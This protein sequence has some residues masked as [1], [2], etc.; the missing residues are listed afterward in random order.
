MPAAQ[1]AC[2]CSECRRAPRGF[3]IQDS[4][5]IKNHQEE[6]LHRLQTTL[7][8]QPVG[9]NR[10]DDV[11]GNQEQLDPMGP[12][13]PGM[14]I[15]GY[16]IDQDEDDPMFNWEDLGDEVNDDTSEGRSTSGNESEVT[17]TDMVSMT[18]SEGRH[19]S[20]AGAD[21]TGGEVNDLSDDPHY[22]ED[23][24]PSNHLFDTIPHHIR[25]SPRALAILPNLPP[26]VHRFVHHDHSTP[27]RIAW[28]Q[29]AVASVGG[30]TV[31]QVSIGL[32]SSNFMMASM[33]PA[34]ELAQPPTADPKEALSRIGV[35]PDS[36]LHRYAVCENEKCCVLFGNAEL[37][38]YD[39]DEG[40]AIDILRPDERCTS[41]IYFTKGRKRYPLKSMFF[42][43]PSAVLQTFF[44]DP[45]FVRDIQLW[46]MDNHEDDIGI[47]APIPTSVPVDRYRVL[48]NIM[49]GAAWRS[50]DCNVVREYFDTDNGP[51]MEDF[52]HGPPQRLVSMEFGLLA[53]INVDWFGVHD[54]KNCSI[55]AIYV[56][57]LNLPRH[58]FLRKR[59]TILAM[60]IPGPKIPTQTGFNNLIAPLIRDFKTLET[61]ILAFIAG[62]SHP[63]PVYLQVMFNVSDMPASRK[64]AGVKSHNSHWPCC[65]CRIRNRDLQDPLAYEWR[66]LPHMN[67]DTLVG[68]ASAH[69]TATVAQ[70]K[71]LEKD[72]G[73]KWSEAVKLSGFKHSDFSPPDTMHG[74]ALGMTHALVLWI[75][76]SGVLDEGDDGPD[77]YQLFEKALTGITWPSH[78]GRLVNGVVSMVTS[79]RDANNVKAD[80]WSRVRAAL[81]CALWLALRSDTNDQIAPSSTHNRLEIYRAVV[82]FSASL[83]VLLAKSITIDAAEEAQDLL[84]SV[85]KRFLLHGMNM[86]INW[87]IAMHYSQ[88]IRMYGPVG[89]Y[90]TW[91]YERNNGA[92]AKIHYFRG[93]HIQMVG[94]AARFWTKSQLLWGVLENPAPDISETE[95]SYIED[96]KCRLQRTRIQGTVLLNEMD[97]VG[98]GIE[99]PLGNRSTI[100]IRTHPLQLYPGILSYL[101]LALPGQRIRSYAAI[102]EEGSV[103]VQ[104]GHKEY[105]Y[106]RFNGFRFVSKSYTRSN[107]D[108]WALAVHPTDRALGMAACRVEM[109]LQ[110]CL[111]D[112]FGSLAD[113]VITVAAVRFL[114]PADEEILPWSFRSV[115]LAQ[116]LTHLPDEAIPPTVI[117]VSSLLAPVAV[118]EV[119]TIH[120]SRLVI[121]SYN[122]EHVED[123]MGLDQFDED[124]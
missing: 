76:R 101:R 87:H 84:S 116:Q 51:V 103:L 99:L 10:A 8:P 122:R 50:R 115:M 17:D 26:F 28:T 29:A 6:D 118:K 90:A 73:V 57:I 110:L 78:V 82:D 53:S 104:A 44:R 3:T 25:P 11:P 80:E 27:E 79:G 9:Y 124:E 21:I 96:L 22:L 16:D 48:T 12:E 83:R 31:D 72:H 43:P 20:D 69:R 30:A 33:A 105:P 13:E 102:Y 2:R 123:S 42:S 47:N 34:H 85:C 114:Q 94:T 45:N 77:R 67:A 86:T 117:S 108:R 18:E 112:T 49:D 61:G 121:M 93:D 41:R 35:S 71:V 120:G 60:V 65:H 23:I 52:R 100:N 39:H 63:A 1:R 91:S 19:P 113:T 38:T 15:E 36:L 98:Q 56:S 68:A 37:S 109:I 55:G 64:L 97:E 111:P 89:S 5:T 106:V 66:N 7:P 46:R 88:F 32:A 95:A 40:H 107:R 70:Q 62:R 4:R 59:W 24:E 14:G 81:P 75:L 74:A 54:I 92:L 119:G 58:I